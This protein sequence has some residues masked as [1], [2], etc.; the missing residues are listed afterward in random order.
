MNGERLKQRIMVAVN[1][2]IQGISLFECKGN[3][4]ALAPCWKKWLQSFQYFLIAKGVVNDAQKKA[5][6]LHTAGK[7]VQELYKMLTDPGTD[8]FEENTATEYEKTV[9]TLNVYFVTKLNE[10]DE[11]HVFRSM[12]Q[13]DG[14][15]VDQFFARLRKQAQNC[16]FNDPDVDIRDQVID[17]CRSLV[18]RRKLLEKENLTLTKVQDVARAM[19]AVDLRAKQMG[20]QREE[21]LSVHKVVQKSPSKSSKQPNKKSGKGWCCRCGQQRHYS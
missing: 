2:E 5:L 16:N 18:L 1:I 10:P 9:R 15:I 11:R 19:E 14:E 21:P 13:Q 8:T 12:T 6:L 3:S 4:S 20:V 17:K 7:E